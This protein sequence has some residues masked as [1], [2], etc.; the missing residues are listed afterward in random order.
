MNRDE[1]ALVVKELVE[2]CPKMD[3]VYLCMVPPT[4]D[5]PVV[6]H[7]YQVHIKTDPSFDE[8]TAKCMDSIAK[9]HKLSIQRIKEEEKMIIFKQH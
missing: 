1:A 6:T 7:G 4:G 2:F 8:E 9:T 3:G 5:T